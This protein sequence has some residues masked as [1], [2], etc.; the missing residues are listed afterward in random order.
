MVPD[1]RT[2]TEPQKENRLER[3]AVEAALFAKEH[4]SSIA[5]RRCSLVADRFAVVVS[6]T[7]LIVAAD[8]SAAIFSA[9][10][11]ICRLVLLL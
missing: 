10:C 11:D 1:A 3:K 8:T 5:I 6:A 2:G 7:L 9:G 4:L